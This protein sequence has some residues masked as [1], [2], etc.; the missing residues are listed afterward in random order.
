DAAALAVLLTRPARARLFHG[1]APISEKE[2]NAKQETP[3]PSRA[4]ATSS[5]KNLIKTSPFLRQSI[6]VSV[7]E[8]TPRLTHSTPWNL[9][10]SCSTPGPR[11]IGPRVPRSDERNHGVSGV[12]ATTE[13]SGFVLHRS[14]GILAY[15]FAPGFFT[16]YR[17][18]FS[19]LGRHVRVVGGTE[20]ILLLFFDP[21]RVT[22]FPKKFACGLVRRHPPF[23]HPR[24]NFRKPARNVGILPQRRFQFRRNNLPHGRQRLLPPHLRAQ[25]LFQLES[26]VTQHAF[27]QL[28]NSPA[29]ARAAHH[30][31]RRPSTCSRRKQVQ[32]T[33]IIRLAQPRAIQQRAVRLVDRNRVDQF[34]NAALDSLQFIAGSRQQQ[35]Q[36]KI[37]HRAHRNFR[38]PHAHRL[39]PHVAKPRRFAQQNRFACAPGNSS[40]R[41][42]RRRRPDKSVRL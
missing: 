3:E 9:S 24:F 10:K 29:R 2:S 14:R 1:K 5:S 35:Q 37:R 40:H 7:I 12:L 22:K 18:L 39:D 30:H 17:S 38:L 20:S 19:H 15:N 21:G 6:L 4:G 28:G 26:L 8:S 36:Y 41:S 42:A 16:S 32:R 25:P 34:E 31:W 33:L 13:R 11:S 27:P 23:P